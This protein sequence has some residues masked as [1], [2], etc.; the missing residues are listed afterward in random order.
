LLFLRR[1][2]ILPLVLVVPVKFMDNIAK[3]LCSDTGK[4]KIKTESKRE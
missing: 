1:I 2:I 4:A 3:V